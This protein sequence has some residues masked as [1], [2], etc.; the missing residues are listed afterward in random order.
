[1]VKL[2][3]ERTGLLCYNVIRRLLSKRQRIFLG[4]Y[5]YYIL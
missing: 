2:T 3:D 4:T 1:M 5:T